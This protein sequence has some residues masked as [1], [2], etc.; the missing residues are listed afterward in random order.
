MTKLSVKIFIYLVEEA[1]LDME[2]G[3]CARLSC[4]GR[5]TRAK[6][7]GCRLPAMKA[8]AQRLHV[9]ACDGPPFFTWNMVE[10]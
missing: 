3:W 7:R 9:K 8:H 5:P 2:K 6:R 10:F 4:N 1:C